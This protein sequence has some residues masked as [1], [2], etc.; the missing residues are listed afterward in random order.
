MKS[1]EID[2]VERVFECTMWSTAFN[3][4]L[5]PGSSL[6]WER[7][8]FNMGIFIML[9]HSKRLSDTSFQEIETDLDSQVFLAC[10]L[11]PELVFLRP[12]CF[13]TARC[14]SLGSWRLRCDLSL[15]V[16]CQPVVGGQS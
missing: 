4:S 15:V 8:R 1:H 3:E 2:S 6:E 7:W 14:S 5:L 16:G 9:R 12:T 10:R 13:S 11:N